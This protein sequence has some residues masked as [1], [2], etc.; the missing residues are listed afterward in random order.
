MNLSDFTTDE[1]DLLL[2]NDSSVQQGQ[3]ETN[4]GEGR[5]EERREGQHGRIPPAPRVYP[6][7]CC[8]GRIESRSPAFAWTGRWDGKKRFLC[9]GCLKM[10]AAKGAR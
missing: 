8:G 10:S 3:Q 4:H 6:C 9:G 1:R 7:D 2:D 5:D